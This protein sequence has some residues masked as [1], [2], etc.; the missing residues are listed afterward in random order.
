MFFL[1][2]NNPGSAKFLTQEER[3]FLIN[4]LR[5]DNDSGAGQQAQDEKLTLKHIYEAL[6]DWRI[7]IAVVGSFISLFT[8]PNQLT[9]CMNDR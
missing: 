2:P 1:L 7:Y 8:R 9:H 4:R 3:D 5:Y 6:K